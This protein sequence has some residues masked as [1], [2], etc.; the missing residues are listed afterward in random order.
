MKIG[1]SHSFLICI[2]CLI[3]FDIVFLLIK[4]IFRLIC[5]KV[6][7]SSFLCFK[8]VS[9]YVITPGPPSLLQYQKR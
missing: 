3:G 5:M 8:S 9:D 6:S 1:H 2:S 4:D 7:F